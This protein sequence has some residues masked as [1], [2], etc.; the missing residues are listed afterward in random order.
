MEQINADAVPIRRIIKRKGGHDGHGSSAW[1]V[2]YADFVTAMMS[3]FIVLWIV[4]E[5]PEIRQ[6]VAQYFKDP[7]VIKGSQWI[8]ETSG[9]SGSIPAPGFSQEMQRP[10][11]ASNDIANEQERLEQTRKKLREAL[12]QLPEFKNLDKQVSMNISPE[13]LRI[14][15][16]EREDS[17]FFEV[18]SA[19]PRLEAA[20]LFAVIA[21]ELSRL[22]NQLAVEGH[23]DS[24]PFGSETYTNWELSADR[25]NAARRLMEGAG[26]PADQIVE[27]RGYA[28]RH[29]YNPRDPTDYRNRR[30]SIIVK[31]LA[32]QSPAAPKTPQVAVKE[33]KKEPP[34]AQ[35]VDKSGLPMLNVA[36]AP[37]SLAY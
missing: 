20:R 16:M 13:G 30:V 33:R 10:E 3:L 26:L 37:I 5:S 29:L 1:K 12:V 18:G 14:E 6:A 31:A 15:L 23:S 7:G 19:I 36:P 32:P 9:L 27:V 21:R 8:M 11:P 17:L 25:A 22:P 4:N 28:D 34:T 35:T 24:R 2:A